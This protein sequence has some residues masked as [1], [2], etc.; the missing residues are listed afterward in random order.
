ML[1]DI[2][3]QYQIASLD[4]DKAEKSAFDQFR[5]WLNDALHS[6]EAEPTAMVVATVDKK[7]QPHCRVVLLK[8]FTDAGLVFF[9]NYESNKA[10]QMENNHQV[11]VLF[12][13]ASLERQVRITGI[14]SKVSKEESEQY[15]YSRPVESRIGA[16]SSP[17][18][19][20]IPD[21]EFLIR[22]FEEAKQQFGE[23][24][25]MPEHWGGY[26]ISTQTFE[27]WQGRPSRLHDRLYYE[28][29]ENGNWKISRL[30]P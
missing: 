11:S 28:L 29:E 22:N 15:F 19:K 2:R 8:E 20:V 17:Q 27:F 10:M 1:H 4:E 21:K 7:M 26:R 24:I 6:A 5:N 18:S 3:K 23:Q 12:H 16:Y 9:S 14:V 30:A 25:P 13:W